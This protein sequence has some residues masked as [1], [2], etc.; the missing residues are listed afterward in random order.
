[1]NK[2]TAFEIA[3]GLNTQNDSPLK[4]IPK[5]ESETKLERVVRYWLNNRAADY[6]D[7][8]RGA[9]KDLEYGGCESGIVDKL[10]YYTD[11]VR[12]YRKHQSEIDSMLKEFLSDLG[13]E[14][15]QGL[16]GDKWDTDDPLARE[17]SNQ[18]LLAWF[19][20]EETARRIAESNGYQ[21]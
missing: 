10:I 21:G 8:W 6:G 3:K 4:R 13:A 14:G 20:F 12:F 16:F 15:P 11:T 9:Y 18:N 5:P 19:G 7:G 1:M 17:D 2:K